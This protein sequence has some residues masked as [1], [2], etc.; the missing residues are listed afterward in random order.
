MKRLLIVAIDAKVRHCGRCNFVSS[1]RDWCNLIGDT[2]VPETVEDDDDGSTRVELLR[3]AACHERE[4]EAKTYVPR[5]E[6]Q[7]L[8]DR[9]ST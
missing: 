9:T 5:E 2:L 8:K 6:M 1:K 7:A 4:I 3:V